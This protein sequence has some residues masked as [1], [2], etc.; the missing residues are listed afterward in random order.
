[1]RRHSPC[2]NHSLPQTN[3]K[4]HIGTGR[5]L[6]MAENAGMSPKRCIRWYRADYVEKVVVFDVGR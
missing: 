2:L 5:A 6:V 4:T 1:M 3:S